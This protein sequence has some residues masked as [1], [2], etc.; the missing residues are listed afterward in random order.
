MNIFGKH[1]ATQSTS[2]N[3]VEVEG[4]QNQR[5]SDADKGIECTTLAKNTT[6]SSLRPGKDQTTYNDEEIASEN[7]KNSLNTEPFIR[8]CS[9][10]LPKIEPLPWTTF[11]CLS[12]WCA[13]PWVSLCSCF[14]SLFTT[15]LIFPLVITTVLQFT[16]FFSRYEWMI[17]FDI[18]PITMPE[19][20]WFALPSIVAN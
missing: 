13:V 11:F 16:F 8:I 14:P 4:N 3:K 2:G 18:I 9:T 15:F 5:D 20:T 17:I 1:T 10:V 7:R 6:E 19:F 12:I